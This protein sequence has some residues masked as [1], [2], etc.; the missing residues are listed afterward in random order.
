M[1]KTNPPVPS[2][3]ATELLSPKLR[4]LFFRPGAGGGAEYI[5]SRYKVPYGGR[6]S[7]KTWGVAGLAVTLG[8][9]RQMRFLCVREYQS[10]IRESVHQ[11]LSSRIIDL[12]L[13][14]YYDVQRDAIIGKQRTKDGDGYRRTEFIFAGVKTDPAKVKGTEDVDVCYIEE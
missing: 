13:S 12:G 7:T 10:S 3:S 6:G 2:P 9:M 1:T 4:D 8:A 5:P 11:I 14:R